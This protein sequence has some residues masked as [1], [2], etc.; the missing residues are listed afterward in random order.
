[1]SNIKYVC[2]HYTN[3]IG[4]NNNIAEIGFSPKHDDS[5]I[6]K[7]KFIKNNA[8]KKLFDYLLKCLNLPQ[9]PNYKCGIYNDKL[10][11]TSDYDEMKD[12]LPTDVKEAI[13]KL[14]ELS[15]KLTIKSK[16]YIVESI[17]KKTNAKYGKNIKVG[18]EV[19]WT[20]DLSYKY[21]SRIVYVN[22]VPRTLSYTSFNLFINAFDLKEKLNPQIQNKLNIF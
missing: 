12:F 22:N 17:N 9:L 5:A 8:D 13:D 11:K 15:E 16:T 4:Y 10:R 3:R 18:D 2:S 21:Q 7:I 6:F 1:M 20:I 19:Y 14:I